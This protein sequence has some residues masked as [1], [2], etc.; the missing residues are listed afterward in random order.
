MEGIGRDERYGGTVSQAK[1]R[2]MIRRKMVVS[3]LT[4]RGDRDGQRRA[5]ILAYLYYSGAD[6]TG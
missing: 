1:K 3:R 5:H 2:M 4:V 6:M